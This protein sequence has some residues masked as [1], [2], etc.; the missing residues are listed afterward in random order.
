[1]DQ[2]PKDIFATEVTEATEKFKFN[3]QK[4]KANVRGICLGV[5]G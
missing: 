3:K 5:R 1:M 2:N 4:E